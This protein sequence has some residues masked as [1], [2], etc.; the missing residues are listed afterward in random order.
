MTQKS[1]TRKVGLHVR[2]LTIKQRRELLAEKI[3]RMRKRANRLTDEN[4]K[5]AVALLNKA[6]DWYAKALG[7]KYAERICHYYD[8]FTNVEIKFWIFLEGGTE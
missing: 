3:A 1:K 5:E 6:E 7:A 8:C 2:I 4:A